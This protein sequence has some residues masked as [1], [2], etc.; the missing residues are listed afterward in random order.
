MLVLT[1]HEYYRKVMPTKVDNLTFD[2][3][4]DLARWYEITATIPPGWKSDH[5][6]EAASRLTN[7]IEAAGPRGHCAR[8]ATMGSIRVARRAGM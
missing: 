3:I 8:S 6:L 7:S 2:P 5:G 1:R 4:H